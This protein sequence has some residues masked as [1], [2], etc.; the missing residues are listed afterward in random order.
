MTKKV[1][2]FGPCCCVIFVLRALDE[3]ASVF[4]LEGDT[5]NESSSRLWLNKLDPLVFGDQVI[6]AVGLRNAVD[7]FGDELT[8]F[9][10]SSSIFPSGSPI[11]T[12]IFF[13]SMICSSHPE[14]VRWP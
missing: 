5:T 9:D 4:E 14:G 6:G 11:A 3:D 10:V 8:D 1:Y 12:K 13:L 2:R 7:S